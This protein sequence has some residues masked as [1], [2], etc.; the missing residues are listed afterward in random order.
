MKFIEDKWSDPV[1]SKV[2]AGII[3]GIGTILVTGIWT[4]IKKI[5]FSNLFVENPNVL[6]WNAD[7]NIFDFS[8]KSSLLFWLSSG[9]LYLIAAVILFF[10]SLFED[11]SSFI[12]RIGIAFFGTFICLSI[13]FVFYWLFSLIPQLDKNSWLWNYLVNFGIQTVLILGPFSDSNLK[14]NQKSTTRQKGGKKTIR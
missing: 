2:I 7:S 11:G 8:Q 14:R 6:D 9:I 13:S 12:T 5:P 10:Q 3:L 1:W 4:I